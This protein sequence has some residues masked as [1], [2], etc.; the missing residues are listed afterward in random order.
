MFSLLRLDPVTMDKVHY[1]ERFIELMI[2][3]EVRSAQWFFC[4][5]IIKEANDYICR[6][7]PMTIYEVF[8][9]HL[10]LALVCTY[11]K[12]LI[13]KKVKSDWLLKFQVTVKGLCL[14]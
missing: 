4:Y 11:F 9:Y 1:C 6:V 14:Y 13:E 2:D 5:I 3:L 7:K 12:C 10:E 8:L